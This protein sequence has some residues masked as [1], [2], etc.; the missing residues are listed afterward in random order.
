MVRAAPTTS[1]PGPTVGSGFTEQ[2]SNTIG[3]ITTNGQENNN[4]PSRPSCRAR[5]RSARTPAVVQRRER[6]GRRDDHKRDRHDVSDG[7]HLCHAGAFRTPRSSS[8]VPT[9]T[10]AD[11]HQRRRRDHDR[12][13]HHDLLF[14]RRPA[15]RVPRSEELGSAE[16]TAGSDGRLW[17]F[18]GSQTRL[19]AL[20]TTGVQSGAF[21]SKAWPMQTS[22][23]GIHDLVSGPDGRLWFTDGY[24]TDAIA[25]VTLHVVAPGGG[26]TTGS[27]HASRR[28]P[29]SRPPARGIGP[30]GQSKQRLRKAHCSLG[31]IRRNTTRRRGGRVVSQH[32]KPGS[33]RSGAEAASPLSW[34]GAAPGVIAPLDARHELRRSGSSSLVG[35]SVCAERGWRALVRERGLG[36]GRRTTF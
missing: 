18:D 34:A 5:S 35:A 17:Y 6:R 24:P 7:R 28:V 26:A 27:G 33:R 4:I 12:W 36:G 16:I 22:S 21:V 3:A 2:G 11:K 13:R 32:P 15:N 10:A 25:A 23:S 29:A 31:A 1:P 19:A 9:A 20:T 30:L 14:R 8:R